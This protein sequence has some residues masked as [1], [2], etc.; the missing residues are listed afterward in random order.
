MFKKKTANGCNCNQLQSINKEQGMWFLIGRMHRIAVVKSPTNLYHHK[1]KS[2]PKHN[3]Q[4][5][6]SLEILGR[7]PP[8]MSGAMCPSC[9]RPCLRLSVLTAVGA[10]RWAS[11]SKCTWRRWEK[12]RFFEANSSWQMPH[13]CAMAGS[14]PGCMLCWSHLL[15]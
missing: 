12:R 1:W 13:W 3:H 7:S 6:N 5:T 11:G 2:S 10:A 8:C 14:A 15:E 4:T 9:C